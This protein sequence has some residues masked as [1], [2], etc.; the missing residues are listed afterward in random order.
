MK[1]KE[2]EKK[3][4]TNY[5]KKCAVKKG[6]LSKGHALCEFFHLSKREKI[7]ILKNSMN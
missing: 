5:V 3:T 6:N 2:E 1:E 7:E 4:R